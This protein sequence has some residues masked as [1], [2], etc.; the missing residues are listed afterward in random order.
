MKKIKL[1]MI[2]ALSAM[3]LRAAD[4][5]EDLTANFVKGSPEIQSMK[6]LA[7]G[8]QGILFVGDNDAMTIYAIL[9][10]ESTSKRSIVG[11]CN[12]AGL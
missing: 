9:P 5:E 4:K 10:D 11:G 6:T 12:D 8:P 2:L 3:I 1:I 7:F